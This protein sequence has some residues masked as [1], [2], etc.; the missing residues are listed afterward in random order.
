M[1]NLVERVIGDCK[2]IQVFIRA[3]KILKQEHPDLVT[4]I[5]PRKPQHGQDIALKLQEE[6]T[7]VALRSCGDNLT[8]EISLYVVDSLGE[9]RDFYSLTPIAVVGGS[10]LPESAGHNILEAAAAGC[11]VFTGHHVG[12]FSHM[13]AEMQRV[14]PL[15]VLQVSSEKLVE[16]V[17]ELFVNAKILETRRVAAKQAYHALSCGVVE[18]L[19]ETVHFHV[20]VKLVG[21]DDAH[22][23]RS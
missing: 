22:G 16:V 8:H 15:S 7:S 19:W 18:K 12:H 2:Y 13:I 3:H 20:F 17:N 4:I 23:A 9:L 5:V 14:N 10:F 6:G 1:S 11:A 21:T